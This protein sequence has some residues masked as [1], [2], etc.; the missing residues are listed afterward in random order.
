M[1]VLLCYIVL[2][3]ITVYQYWTTRLEVAKVRYAQE[4][5]N[6]SSRRLVNLRAGFHPV[7]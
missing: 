2:L 5:V 4:C 7:G 6:T 3:K 1:T